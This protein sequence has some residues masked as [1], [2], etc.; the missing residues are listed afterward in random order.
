ML[1]CFLVPHTK[2][3]LKHFQPVVVRRLSVN[4]PIRPKPV[5]F[6]FSFAVL[7]KSAATE[8]VAALNI[9]DYMDHIVYPNDILFFTQVSVVNKL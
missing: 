4:Q 9:L 8:L 7:T 1:K 3:Q 2:Q 6:L 5:R